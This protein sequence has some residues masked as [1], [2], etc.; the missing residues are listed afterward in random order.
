M[1]TGRGCAL[2]VVL[3][4]RMDELACGFERAL[5]MRYQSSSRS[6]VSFVNRSSIGGGGDD[7]RKIGVGV[8]EQQSREILNF[9]KCK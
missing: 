8:H 3:T 7:L 5:R 2:L 9:A 6:V 4:Q 1:N